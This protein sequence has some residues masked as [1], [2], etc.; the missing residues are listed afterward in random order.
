V[1][2]HSFGQNKQQCIDLQHS[3]R[4]VS[5]GAIK[6]ISKLSCPPCQTR[7]HPSAKISAKGVVAGREQNDLSD[8]QSMSGVRQIM[9]PAEHL[10]SF[11]DMFWEALWRASFPN[12]NLM[13][14]G[15]LVRSAEIARA[16]WDWLLSFCCLLAWLGG[17]F[18]S[19]YH[20]VVFQTLDT[21]NS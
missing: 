15:V 7:T 21:C 1:E 4:P 16:D 3:W 14:L 11:L 18:Y 5:E 19:C 10:S 13:C 8:K 9:F 2:G 17:M 12:E 6:I 20:V